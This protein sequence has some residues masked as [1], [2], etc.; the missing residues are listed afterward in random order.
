MR[1]LQTLAAWAMALPFIIFF[2]AVAS[3]SQGY[4]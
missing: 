3:T 2:Y 4:P 1:W